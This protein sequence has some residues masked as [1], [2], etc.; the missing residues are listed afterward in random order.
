MS[1]HENLRWYESKT[2]NPL[3][4]KTC[5]SVKSNPLS[6]DIRNTGP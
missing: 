4:C 5:Q 1:E 3:F 2:T 6:T